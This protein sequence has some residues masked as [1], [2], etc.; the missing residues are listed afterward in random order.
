VVH[1]LALLL[2]VV[3]MMKADDGSIA[4]SAVCGVILL[5]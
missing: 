1:P 2:L 3:L 4:A 5:H